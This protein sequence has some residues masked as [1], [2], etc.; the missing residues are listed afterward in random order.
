MRE[1]Y[2]PELEA[3]LQRQEI[4]VAIT[5][6]EKKPPGGMHSAVLLELPLVLLVPKRSPIKARRNSGSGTKSPSR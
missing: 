2:Q 6:M 1:G 5:L 3:M 4:D